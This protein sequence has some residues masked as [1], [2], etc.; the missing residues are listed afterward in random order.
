MSEARMPSDPPRWI[1]L[2]TID[3][4]DGSG[5]TRRDADGLDVIVCRREGKLHVLHNRCSH[6]GQPLDGGKVVA[7]RIFCPFHGASFDVATGQPVAGPAMTALHAFA[8]RVD[9]GALYVD[10]SVRPHPALAWMSA[11][12]SRA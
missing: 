6:A 1:R 5:P 11:M 10:V 8:T 2:G 12:I 9:A 7:G 4:F 3:E